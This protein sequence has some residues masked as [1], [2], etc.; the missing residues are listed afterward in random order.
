[1][2]ELSRAR[3][4]LELYSPEQAA[5]G[6]ARTLRHGG[7]V[8]LM[9]DVPEAGP[10]VAVRFCGGLVRFSSVPARLAAATGKPIVPVACW[11]EAPGWVLEFFAPIWPSGAGEAETMAAIAAVL[12]P[13]VSRHPEHY[14]HCPES[15]PL[16]HR[17]RLADRSRC[18]C[19]CAS[20]HCRCIDRCPAVTSTKPL[21]EQ[22]ERQLESAFG[23]GAAAAS[24]WAPGRCTLVGEHVDYAG[25]FVL[26]FA[27]DLGIAVAARPSPDGTFRLAAPG[28]RVERSDPWPA[29]DAADRVFAAAVALRAAGHEVPP[30]ELGI[31]PTLPEGAGLASSAAVILATLDALLQLSG[32]RARAEDLASMALRAEREIVGVP[33]GPLDP[34]AIVFA[35]P[36]G[37]ALVDCGAGSATPVS[38][39]AAGTVVCLA[40]SGERHDVGGAAYRSRRD[41]CDRAL[42]ALRVRTC[43]EITPAAPAA[44]ALDEVTRRRAAHL[45]DESRRACEAADALGSGDVVHLGALMSASHRSLRDLYEVSTR[46][47]DRM[48][49]A[50]EAVGGCL[51]SR[52]VGAGFGGSVA[53]LA[54]TEAALECCAALAA[55]AAPGGGAT[56]VVRPAPG[57]AA[58][59]PNLAGSE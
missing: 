12:E 52:L 58:V 55:A 39:P 50:V 40:D 5:R 22:A 24:G 32:E 30:V 33:C 16:L 19:S 29:G 28:R 10:T 20:S 54:R 57:L 51:G 31:A 36:G 56:W 59:S 53:A 44:A 3:K 25:G 47:L 41:E 21:I 46:V 7:L 1:M 8:A 35:P 18:R 9:V 14:R 13:R 11:R 45:G 42:A 37:A 4:G 49:V 15:P 34:L 26:A 48:V 17:M 43:R 27:V 6:L 2:V 23:P 38:W